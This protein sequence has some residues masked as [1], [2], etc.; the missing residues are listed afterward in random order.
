MMRIMGKRSRIIERLRT[1]A[2]AAYWNSAC[3]NVTS[4]VDWGTLSPG[5]VANV[6]FYLRN[7]GNWPMRLYLTTQNWNPTNASSYI[8]VSWNREAQ[9]LAAGNV[10][11]ATLTLNVSAS[12]SGVAIFSFETVFTG[13]EQ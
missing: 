12:I 9:T 13:A 8:S 3:T 6:S 5:N 1:S 4:T 2:R 7:E 11:L 10:I